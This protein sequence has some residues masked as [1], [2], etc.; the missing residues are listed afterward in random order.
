MIAIQPFTVT[1]LIIYRNLAVI[2]LV[3]TKETYMSK[4]VMN[5]NVNGLKERETKEEINV[6]CEKWYE[7]KGSVVSVTV[8]RTVEYDEP[9]LFCCE[10][11]IIFMRL[12]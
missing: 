4:R 9:I 11:G 3:R 10:K 2:V 1:R 6:L 5:L 7:R 8:D 12:A